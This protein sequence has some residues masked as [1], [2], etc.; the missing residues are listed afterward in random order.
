M[1]RAKYRKIVWK[2]AHNSDPVD[3]V[4]RPR[5]YFPDFEL[6][7]DRKQFLAPHLVPGTLWTVKTPVLY[8]EQIY[9]DVEQPPFPYAIGN[10]YV[11]WGIN[12]KT[13]ARNALA[14][15]LGTTRVEESSRDRRISVPRHTF[16]VDGVTYITRNLND[17]EPVV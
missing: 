13:H 17:W 2:K 9:P 8:P 3:R 1:S 5:L 7:E 11:P 16:I 10:E 14:I 12:T 4:I 6:E 15:Y